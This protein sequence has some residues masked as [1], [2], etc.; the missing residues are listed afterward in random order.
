LELTRLWSV[1]AACEI[2]AADSLC[3]IIG[4]EVGFDIDLENRVGGRL[5]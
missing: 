4:F 3:L 2:T 5:K 1:R